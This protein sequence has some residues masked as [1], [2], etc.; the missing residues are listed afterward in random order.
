[1][2]FR[3]GISWESQTSSFCCKARPDVSVSRARRSRSR[4]R[5]SSVVQLGADRVT[6]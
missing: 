1:M 6:S 3:E 5:R 2:P 4:L